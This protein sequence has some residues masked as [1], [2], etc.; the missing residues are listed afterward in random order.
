M[1][2]LALSPVLPKGMMGMGLCLAE[3]LIMVICNSYFCN[4][5]SLCSLPHIDQHG[6][7]SAQWVIPVVWSRAGRTLCVCAGQGTNRISYAQEVTKNGITP[8]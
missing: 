4:L 5:P 7:L 2:S 3:G 6:F 1:L 8:D